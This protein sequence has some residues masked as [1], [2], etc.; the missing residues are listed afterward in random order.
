MTVLA[1]KISLPTPPATATATA[2]SWIHEHPTAA[3]TTQAASL[4]LGVGALSAPFVFGANIMTLSLAATGALLTLASSVALA[5]IDLITPPHHE[6]KNHVYQSN[7]C[8]GGKLYYQGDIPILSLDADN[9]FQAGKAQGYLCGEAISRLTKRFDWALHTLLKQP[10]ANALP[11]ILAA[12]RKQIPERYLQEIEGLVEGYKKWADEQ[13]W[14]RFPNQLTIEDA[15]L[16]HLMPDSLHFQPQAWENWLSTQQHAASIHPI[17]LVACTALVDQDDQN[18]MVLA[19]NMDWPSFGLAGTYSLLVHRK[20]NQTHR[21]TIEIGVPGLVG[22]LTGMNDRGLALAMNVC[23]GHTM[24]IHG[25]PALFYNRSCLE[26]CNNVQEV[27]DQVQKQSPLGAYHLTATDRDTGASIHFY[28]GAEG[29]HTVRHWQNGN[30]LSTLNFRYSPAPSTPTHYCG[31][32]QQ[33]INDFFQN[34]NRRPLEDA[35]ALP[36]VNNWL[37]THRALLIPKTKTIKVAF[38][39]AFAGRASFHSLSFDDLPK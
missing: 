4:L 26:Q 27:Q 25:M 20:Y 34:R 8:E 3:K 35:L 18:G 39:N 37:T 12:I 14:W 1:E 23:A 16:L 22:T 9:P 24:R 33:Y 5:T 36:F 31:Q 28:Q 11:L 32:R 38:D 2:S 15:L 6:M 21:N 19:R 17:P 29:N 30:P 7:E 13:P 10:R